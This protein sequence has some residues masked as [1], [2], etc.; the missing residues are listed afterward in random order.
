MSDLTW[1]NSTRK[2]SDLIPWEN[3]PRQIGE[4]DAARLAESLDQFG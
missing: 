2:L 1:T 4:A 3:N